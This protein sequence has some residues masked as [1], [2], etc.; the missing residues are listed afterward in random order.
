V[1]RISGEPKFVPT[2]FLSF[3]LSAWRGSWTADQTLNPSAAALEA[4]IPFWLC[5]DEMNLAP[6]EQYFADYLSV[7]EQREWAGGRY[8]CP[9][10]SLFNRES[11]MRRA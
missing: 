1:S 5:L 8:L 3:F 11:R 6:V 10:C 4:M 7:L 2:R 9:P